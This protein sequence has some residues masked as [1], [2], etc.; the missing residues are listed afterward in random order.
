[1]P[2]KRNLKDALLE[3]LQSEDFDDDAGDADDDI[4]TLRGPS[5]RKFLG[6]LDDDK[7]TGDKPAAEEDPD[8]DPAPEPGPQRTQKKYFGE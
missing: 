4:I 8:A 5:A 1:M 2:R 6:L 7:P 3:F